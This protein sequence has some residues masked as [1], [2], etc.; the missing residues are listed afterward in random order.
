MTVKSPVAEL[1]FPPPATPTIAISRATSPALPD[2]AS[3]GAP[4]DQGPADTEVASL[5][6]K[7]VLPQFRLPPIDESDPLAPVPD[8]DL[9]IQSEYGWL[10][11]ISPDGRQSWQV[12]AR[13]F[14]ASEDRP[15]VGIMVGSLGLSQSATLAAIQQLPGSITLGFNPYAPNLQDWIN[16][17]RAGGHEVMLQLPMEPFDYPEND[18]GPHTLLTSLDAEANIERAEWVLSRFVGYVGV[19]N[20]M[21][22]RFTTSAGALKPV[23]DLVKYRGLMFL[24]SRASS[25]SIVGRMAREMGLVEASN[26]RF[27]DVVASRAAIDE[28]LKELEVVAKAGNAAIGIAFPYPVTIERLA[29]W[30]AGLQSRGITL[31]PISAFGARSYVAQAQN[32]SPPESR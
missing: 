19:T 16:Q 11:V 25:H 9:V 15:L 4:I 7:K 23:L 2:D 13:P 28:R 32:Q 1:A 30:A 17:A 14:E 29:G 31:A 24:D 21:G 12:Y 26:S 22:S 10:P 20:Y 27:V 5:T 18:P 6:P 3:A 8:P